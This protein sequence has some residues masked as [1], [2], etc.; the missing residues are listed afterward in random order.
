MRQRIGG[1]SLS[2]SEIVSRRHGVIKV[3]V[4]FV[5]M[6]DRQQ[7]RVTA[8][9]E[10]DQPVQFLLH[11]LSGSRQ[12]LQGNR[13]AGEEIFRQEYLTERTLAALRQQS[14]SADDIARSIFHFPAA[15]KSDRLR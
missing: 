3:I 1:I 2:G 7:I 8:G 11:L 14:V 15:P 6:Q 4:H 5:D 10:T 12:K 13:L 9:T